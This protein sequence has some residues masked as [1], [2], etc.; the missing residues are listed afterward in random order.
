ME[1]TEAVRLNL[2]TVLA[3]R[4]N[5]KCADCG[6]EGLSPP[7]RMHCG[8]GHVVISMKIMANKLGLTNSQVVFW[9]VHV[10]DTYNQS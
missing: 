6:A 10:R 3:K 5:H 9:H 7:H 1:T 8:G 2:E 4:D